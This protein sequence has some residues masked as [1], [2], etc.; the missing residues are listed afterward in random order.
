MG[1]VLVWFGLVERVVLSVCVSID[2]A[3]LAWLYGRMVDFI[4]FT[5]FGCFDCFV[6]FNFVVWFGL[7][8]L[9][10]FF[11]VVTVLAL[12]SSMFCCFRGAWLFRL[13]CLFWS[14]LGSSARMLVGSLGIF[15]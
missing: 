2:L 9:F 8:L 12:S 5:C 10:C 13:F 3:W 7:L 11:A 6:F 14:Q 4:S 1:W 15:C